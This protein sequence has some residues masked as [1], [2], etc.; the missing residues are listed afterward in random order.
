MTFPRIL[1]GAVMAFA[2]HSG[3]TVPVLAEATVHTESSQWVNCADEGHHCEPDTSGLVTMRYGQGDDYTYIVTKGVSKIPCD[4]SWGDPSKGH[5][6]SCAYTTSNLLAVPDDSTFAAGVS[7]DHNL[8]LTGSGKLHWVRYG[9]EGKWIYTLI[10]SGEEQVLPCTNDYFGFDP[11][12]GTTK[13]CQWGDYFTLADDTPGEASL[14]NCATEGQTCDLLA[15]VPVLM[16]YGTGTGYDW[17]FVHASDNQIKCDNTYFGIDPKK[18]DNKACAYQAMEPSTVS[19]IGSWQVVVT[20][21]GAGC[22]ISDSMSFGTEKTSTWSTS[23][24]WSLTVTESVEEGLE[25]EGVGVKANES[26]STGFALSAGYQ[27]AL[28]SSMTETKTVTCDV[29]GNQNSRALY[30]FLTA[31]EASCLENGNCTGQT[32]TSDYLCVNDPPANYP[33]PACIPG[34]CAPGDPLCLTCTY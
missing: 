23:A 17:R 3:L 12:K 7:E 18:G 10:A 8:E 15:S 6:K 21:V 5:D 4:N 1:S 32:F 19:T 22:V 13:S 24:E 20:C 14:T 33:G 25:I 28:S 16:R 11:D 2:C 34:T 29:G 27:S 9:A 30:Q 31:T 26:V